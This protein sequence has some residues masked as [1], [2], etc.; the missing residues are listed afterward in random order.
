MNVVRQVVERYN[1]ELWNE[2]RY[3]IARE[4]IGDSV[5][6]NSPGGRQ[7][8]TRDESV[9][10]IRDAWNQ[11]ERIEFELLHTI[12]EVELCTI[13]YQAE[14]RRSDGAR[15]SIASIEVFRVSD[16]RIVEV[17]NNSHDHNR[18]PDAKLGSK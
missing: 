1:F 5:I 3:E 11:F 18:W 9:Q 7:V 8:L 2:Q 6:R 10:R 12:V 13:V 17:W 16:G 15:D 4:V 14:M